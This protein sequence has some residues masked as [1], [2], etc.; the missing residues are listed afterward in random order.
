M[1][2]LILTQYYPPESGAAQNRLSDLARRLAAFG[3]SVSVLTALPSYP[4]GEVYEGYRGRFTMS[5]VDNGINI[6]RI[7]IYAT[8]KRNFVPRLVNYISFAA[9]SLFVGY[10]KLRKPDVV[11]VESPPLFLGFSGYLLA[12]MK[13][14]K[15]VFNVSDLWPES[16]VALGVLRNRNLILWATRVEEWLYRHACL[17]TGQTQGIVGSIRKRC[18]ECKVELMTNGVSPEFLVSAA[19]AIGKR[20]SVRREFGVSGK[21]VIG[22][23]GLHGLVYGLDD[24]LKAA[25]TLAGFDEIHFLLVGDGPEKPRLKEKAR[26]DGLS[27]ISF[28]DTL[29]AGRMPE[30]FTA[31][32]VALISLRRHELFKGTLPAKL[33]EAMGAGIPVIGAMEGEAQRVIEKA[34]C[35][36]SVEPEDATAIAGAILTLFRDPE[37]RRKL[38]EN[39]RAYASRYYN[40]KEIAEQFEYLLVE[41]LATSR[42][43]FDEVQKAGSSEGSQRETTNLKRAPES[44]VEN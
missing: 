26:L 1:Q 34:N 14:A 7:W 11:F 30:I 16:A 19:E 41:S 5:E 4:K 8:K 43:K 23:A 44:K 24:I 3:H 40:R 27:N 6:V 9:L 18:P 28:F 33:F 31:M 35:G 20:D 22:F 38:G 21:F 29:N 39:G 13:G 32:D 25:K 36:I 17:V 10:V 42:S 37:L 2:I 15:F 12:A